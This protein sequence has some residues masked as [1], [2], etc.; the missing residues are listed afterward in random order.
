[1]AA[2]LALGVFVLAGVA[3]WTALGPFS[4]PG[5]GAAAGGTRAVV[6]VRTPEQTREAPEATFTNGLSVAEAALDEYMWDGKSHAE[7]FPPTLSSFLAVAQGT[8]LELRGKE[9]PDRTWVFLA[10]PET[11]AAVEGTAGVAADVAD[12]L[13]TVTPGK[14][15][16]VIQQS[17]GCHYDP[18]S[19]SSCFATGGQSQHQSLLTF[20]FGVTIVR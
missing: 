14:Y 10:D 6:T 15:V 18:S 12:H 2:V 16:L 8:P 1:M 11:F 9:D 5:H 19:A 7:P 3:V 13:F 4:G 17:W 20:Y